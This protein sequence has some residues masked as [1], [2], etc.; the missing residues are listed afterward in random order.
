MTMA[1]LKSLVKDTAIYGLS[2]ILG[3]FFNYLLVPL[4]TY[5]FKSCSDYGLYSYLYAQ[6]ALLLAILTFGMETTFFRFINKEEDRT[7]KMRVY[8]TALIMV[9][10]VA[11]TF[12]V[13]V[14]SFLGPIARLE[15]CEGHEWYVGMMALVVA[16]DAF[17]AI[18]YAYL[19]NEH[20]PVKFMC[21][22]LILIAMNLLLNIGA[23]MVMPRIDP[24]WEISVKWAFAI[25][26]IC[27]TFIS[28]C[29][30][31]ELTGFKWVFDK[32]KARKMIAYAW[33]I[34][35]LSV[36]GILNNVAGQILL[37]NILGHE[38][39]LD[40]LGIYEACIKVAMI[41]ALITQA[42]RYAYEPFVFGHAKEKD[43]K[44]MY[45]VAMKY[46]II[47]T[48]AAFL[49][50]MGYMDI[51]QLLIGRD[52]REGLGII[53][54]A[55]A[56]EIMMGIAMN[57]SFWYKLIDKT[58]YGAWFSIAGCAALLIV[59]F[60]FVPT[61]GYWACAWGG[62]AAYGTTMVLSYL[63]G[64][65]INPIPYQMKSICGYVLLAGALYAVMY[66]SNQ[67]IGNQWF[68]MGVNTLLI[69]VYLSVAVCEMITK[70]KT[71][72]T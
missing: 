50:V 36:A 37:P 59:N 42:F 40:Q 13:L 65:R 47:F 12:V 6:T 62:F 45:S 24:T 61:Y 34:L 33:P 63:F 22:R 72:T 66:Y 9:G 49:C 18:C 56:A 64:Q 10:G 32:A 48:L 19:R 57:L 68:R 5:T 25:N 26:L 60:L 20:K 3:R 30:Y 38:D 27:T 8:S 4:F 23:Y 28:F 14:L 67:M 31:K 51:L 1:N 69:L 29:F 53:P 7:Q 41:M 55:M 11:L 43:S 2:S 71:K 15:G 44:A 70:T 54:V 17:Q 35:I 46:F 39:G 52:Y 58:I 16:Q 21:L